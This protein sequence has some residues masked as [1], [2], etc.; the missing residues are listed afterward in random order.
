MKS[1]RNRWKQANQC[2]SALGAFAPPAAGTMGPGPASRRATVLLRRGFVRRAGPE[3]R[4][5]DHR[6]ALP[7][8]RK[9]RAPRIV[10]FIICAGLIRPVLK[11]GPRS[12][13]CERV[14][15][16]QTPTR[17]ETEQVPEP[18]NNG[19]TAGRAMWVL[20]VAEQELVC[21]DPKDGEL[22]LCRVKSLET[23]MEARSD[24]D[25]QIV[26]LT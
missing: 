16:W 3:P 10:P 14:S 18:Y 2:G 19:R 8:L 1:A 24:T 5:S 20:P 22:C 13:T 26:R 25:V 17:R 11:H 4:S 21:W 15:G 7:F 6:R 9:R 23:V 12:L